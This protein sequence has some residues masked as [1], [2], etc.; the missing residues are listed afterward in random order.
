MATKQV[1]GPYRHRNRWRVHVRSTQ[2]GTRT[3][4]AESFA[5]KEEA[6]AYR[7]KVE[8]KLAR[9][10]DA[11]A[12][13]AEAD[14]LLEEADRLAAR[15]DRQDG[16]RL[17]VA[18]AIEAYLTWTRE[19]K[20]N[21]DS[22][23]TTTGFRLRGFFGD[24]TVPL[25]SLTERK[26]AGIYAARRRKN[27]VD[28]HRNE[29]GQAK[30]FLN[31]CVE[32]GWFRRNPLAKVKPVGK[33]RTGK[34]QLRIN[35]TKRFCDVALEQARRTDAELRGR[36][37]ARNRV[38]AL[39]VLVAVYLGLRASEVVN[40]RKR[41]VDAH[42]RLLWIGEAKTEDGRRMLEV[43]HVLRRL[44]WARAQECGA[45]RGN[46]G[47]SA[48][49]GADAYA[50]L[51]PHD[52]RWVLTNVKRLC[53]LAGVPEVTA[54]GARGIHAS[55]ATK[56]GATGHDVARAL[57]HKGPAV[58]RRH[59]I[60][61]GATEQ[62]ARERFWELLEDDPA[63]GDPLGQLDPTSAED[64]R[65]RGSDPGRDRSRDDLDPADE[66]KFSS[67][68]AENDRLDPANPDRRTLINRLVNALLRGDEAR[69]K[70]V[71][72]ILDLVT[73][74]EKPTEAQILDWLKSLKSGDF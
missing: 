13:R 20:G 7:R 26:A 27:C 42:G 58:T 23:V 72:K 47:G 67:I 5:S 50:R 33:R 11:A 6:L 46:A 22:T 57:G 30:T 45:E 70:W 37:D 71:T 59:Y 17:T 48:G 49:D 14:R 62:A 44:L 31:W 74:G 24:L 21:K 36:R 65:N 52:R 16:R 19:V 2:N 9:E 29:L 60:R 55:V 10:A 32:K 25:A 61:A 43:P 41:D 8:R 4:R 66:K 18:H 1:F 64:D 63:A 51:F 28:T 39:A 3:V 69:S 12:L 35:E 38:S 56:A 54:H 40:I 53:R 15:A 68:E 34:E 73:Q